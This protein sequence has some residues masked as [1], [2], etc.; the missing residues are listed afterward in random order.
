MVGRL[1]PGSGW[2]RTAGSPRGPPVRA[3]HRPSRL[4]ASSPTSDSTDKSTDSPRPMGRMYTPCGDRAGG[5]VA[6]PKAG[7]FR[8]ETTAV[9]VERQPGH[10]LGPAELEHAH[11]VPAGGC[12]PN[13]GGR[14]AWLYRGPGILTMPRPRREW[15][16]PEPRTLRL[17]EYRPR[18][19]RLRRAD[20]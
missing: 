20:V 10:P 3:I 12:R 19:V 13:N 7:R 14:R 17:T 9:R 1:R 11:G 2:T 8:C 4:K 6:W 16:M 5:S 18:E 15:Q